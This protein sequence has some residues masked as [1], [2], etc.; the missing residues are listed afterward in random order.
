MVGC[1][2]IERLESLGS[3]CGHGGTIRSLAFHPTGRPLA[4]GGDDRI[5]RLWDV[6]KAAVV[7]THEG[8]LSPISSL[9]F[10]PDGEWLATG[11][12]DG[13]L[14]LWGAGGAGH[15]IRRAPH[16]A[17]AALAFD[18]IGGALYAAH[19][20]GA[21][22]RWDLDWAY[23][24]SPL[25]VGRVQEL[26]TENGR[27]ARPRTAPS[28][29]QSSVPNSSLRPPS[30]TGKSGNH[31]PLWDFKASN[32]SKCS[33]QQPS[34]PS[35]VIPAGLIG[36]WPAPAPWTG[37]SHRE[38]QFRAGNREGAASDNKGLN[39]CKPRFRPVL[40]SCDDLVPLLENVHTAVFRDA[41]PPPANGIPLAT[42]PLATLRHR[43]KCII[44]HGLGALSGVGYCRCARD[45]VG[46]PSERQH[47]RPNQSAGNLGVVPRSRRGAPMA[48]L[49]AA[50]PRGECTRK[51]DATHA[52]VEEGVR[53]WYVVRR[54]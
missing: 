45:F 52:L 32:S 10:S 17:V 39:P 5:V 29:K 51:E 50:S 28:L 42:I 40:D 3:L 11:D 47:R 34:C 14:R 49:A 35:D 15:L 41:P 37:S 54:W 1:V 53:E 27:C 38:T 23:D 7:Q 19:H 30:W 12:E 18:N 36:K 16:D 33:E 25:A 24:V 2:D 4:S 20:S 9:G 48:L 22:C 26:K 43:P 21:I 31:A 8:H 46:R 6:E 13:E 44:I